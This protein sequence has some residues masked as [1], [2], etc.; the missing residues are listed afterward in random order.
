MIRRLR[1]RKLPIKTQRSRKIKNLLKRIRRQ[2]VARR[3]VSLPRTRMLRPP[4]EMPRRMVLKTSQ[5]PRAR[6]PCRAIASKLTSN[7]S[8]SRSVRATRKAPHEHPTTIR[9]NFFILYDASFIDSFFE[10]TG[11]NMMYGICTR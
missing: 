7:V 4:R 2:P 8:L 1:F 6:L 3:A 11:L 9:H 10:L 5:Q